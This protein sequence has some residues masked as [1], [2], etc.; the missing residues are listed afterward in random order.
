[1]YLHL[2][3]VMLARDLDNQAH[4]E[5][6]APEADREASPNAVG[7]WCCDECSDKGAN[8]ELCISAGRYIGRKFAF[9]LTIATMRPERTLEK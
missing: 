5:N 6:A 7:N 1:M 4:H 9:L 8:G 3:P 2:V